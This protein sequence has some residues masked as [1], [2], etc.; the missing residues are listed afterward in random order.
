LWIEFL[1]KEKRIAAQIDDDFHQKR[2]G[3]YGN[4]NTHRINF[5][6]Y[7]M[8]RGGWVCQATLQNIYE[9]TMSQKAKEVGDLVNQRYINPVSPPVP[10]N[11]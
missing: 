7:I 10:V 5:P 2:I 3:R 1:G 4:A 6:V 8:E 11:K 9:H